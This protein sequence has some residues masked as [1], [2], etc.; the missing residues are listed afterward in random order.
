MSEKFFLRV[1]EDIVLGPEYVLL[2]YRAAEGLLI[3]LGKPCR[4]AE[5]QRRNLQYPQN[6]LRF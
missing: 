6:P 2:M 3:W 4:L 5:V 1:K